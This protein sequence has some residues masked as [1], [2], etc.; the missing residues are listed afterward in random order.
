MLKKT[1]LASAIAAILFTPTPAVLAQDGLAI[2]EVV[3]TARKRS[4]N[5]QEVPIAITAFTESTI[6][7][8][9]IERPQDFIALTSNVSIVDTANAGDTQV[10]IRGITSTRDAEGTFAYVVDGV[11]ITNPNGFNQE[12]FD[13]QQIEVLKGPQGALYGRNAVAGAILVTTKRPGDEVASAVKVGAGSDGLLSARLSVN[14]PISETVKGAL[15]LSTRK[16]DGQFTNEYTGADDAVDFLEERNLRARLLFTPSEKLE[17]DTTLGFRKVDAGAIN[18]NAVFALPTA[19]AAF[20]NPDL[21][22]DVNDH[23][24][25]F[26]FNVPGQNE[27]ENTFFSLK[28]DYDLEWATL[29]TTLAYDDLEEFLISDGTSAAFGLYS[30]DF[31]VAAGAG[32]PLSGPT[33]GD[34]Q[35]ACSASFQ[36]L[37]L[38]GAQNGLLASPFFAFPGS[39]PGMA[40]DLGIAPFYGLNALLPPYTPSTCDGYQYQKRDQTSTSLEVRLASEGDGLEWQ[41]GMY[42]AQIDREVAVSYGADLGDGVFEATPYVAGRTDLL[43]WDDFDTEVWS[44]FGA[45]DFEIAEHH[46]ISLS[47]RYDIEDREVRNKVPDVL[48]ASAFGGGSA[49]NP[50]FGADTTVGNQTIPNRSDDYSQ[51]QPKVSWRWDV[52]DDLSMYASYGVGFRS[53]GFNNQGSA[54]L[55]SS[56]FAAIPTRP[57]NLRDEYDKEVSKSLELGIKSELMDNR[58]RLNAAVFRTEVDDNQ[59]FNFL[60]GSFGILRVIN[61]I[62]EVTLQGAEVDFQAIMNKNLTLYGGLGLID[63]EIEKNTNRP[64]TEGNKAPLTPD[65]TANLGL[66]WAG[67]VTEAIEFR[68]RLDWQYVGETWFSTV[69]D[70]TTLNAFSD[71]SGLY[72]AVGL[73][74]GDVTT[75][76]P[77][78]PAGGIIAF[79]ESRYDK[80]QRD[81]YDTLNLRLSLESEKWTV[82]AWGDNITDERY[83]EEIIPAPEFGGYFVHPG[84]GSAYGV[85]FNYRF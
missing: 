83:L 74:F 25:R 44:I 65:A 43:F 54:A 9:G 32:S 60:A 10:T 82:T 18:F 66:Q 34:A 45:V 49:I 72:Q 59:F 42:Y 26:I 21:Y 8:A 30:F 64:Y 77:G 73:A 67:S 63:S 84:K 78:I 33:V 31:G 1:V 40:V 38:G 53:G 56:V 37:A 11:L 41:A 55:V 46:L 29:V 76:G 19:A 48:S 4:E 16:D 68:A 57:A 5:L 15:A 7:D 81:A 47:A 39:V 52:S 79:G 22:K 58:V 12:L 27:Q 80:G 17:V 36:N 50:A 24:F 3:V 13:L 23:D 69:Q 61:N 62:D 2:E 20:G 71:V 70:E 14:G 28:A 85:D 51:L 35:N 6:Q 75:G